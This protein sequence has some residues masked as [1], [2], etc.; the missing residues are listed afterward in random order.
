MSLKSEMIKVAYENEDIRGLLLPVLTTRVASSEKD[1]EKRIIRLAYVEPS[2][3][4]HVLPKIASRRGLIKVALKDAPPEDMS[5][6]ELQK[7]VEKTVLSLGFD[8]SNPAHGQI[9]ESFLSMMS[10][11]KRRVPVEGKKKGQKDI[12]ASYA[13]DILEDSNADPD[14][15]K[16]IAKYLSGSRDFARYI[17]ESAV[18]ALGAAK[19]SAS[20]GL[21]SAS[22][23]RAYMGDKWSS[24]KDM[25]RA[26]ARAAKKVKDT[27]KK[28]KDKTVGAG[29]ATWTVAKPM[30]K[31]AKFGA[32]AAGKIGGT[33]LKAIGEVALD[34]SG[35]D[36][37]A[38]GVGGKLKSI[39]DKEMESISGSTKEEFQK[40][41]KKAQ[42]S[43]KGKLQKQQTSARLM[44]SQ[45]AGASY[46]SKAFDE[47]KSKSDKNVEKTFS[48][49]QGRGF[50]SKMR[51]GVS[52]AT[53]G[54]GF[55]AVGMAC[56]MAG[57]VLRGAP[58]GGGAGFS[59][60]RF[61]SVDPEETKKFISD[62]Q[63]LTKDST[64]KMEEMFNDQEFLNQ[65]ATEDGEIDY[66][67]MYD[68]L[69]EKG[70]EDRKKL[71]DEV[72]EEF[73]IPAKKEVAT[74]KE[75]ISKKALVRTAYEN[76]KARSSLLSLIQE[77]I[78]SYHYSEVRKALLAPSF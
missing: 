28:V 16:D 73:Y 39:Y 31:A 72:I 71:M 42:R 54:L 69:Q 75:F 40:E 26:V 62:L 13:A 24:L 36:M 63:E 21:A 17:S 60:R 20:K 50:M 34:I 57:D 51:A 5:E 76:P 8:P 74:A 1:L 2:L 67:A 52:T 3:R 68:H 44:A 35:A 66:M 78:P 45:I 6:A 70:E 15:K 59:K 19:G 9:A 65:F 12:S 10:K 48:A 53:A 77:D 11:E 18:S 56:S 4:S 27:S 37:D 22:T 32:K 38:D 61:A 46:D 25:G 49:N 55:Y 33:I 64:K 7:Y 41:L 30:L 58:K 29:K 14:M 43:A 47:A 23:V